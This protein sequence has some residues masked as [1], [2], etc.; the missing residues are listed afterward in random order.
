[1]ALLQTEL[2]YPQHSGESIEIRELPVPRHESAQRRLRRYCVHMA[3]EDSSSP[4][5]HRMKTIDV[6]LCAAALKD[7]VLAAD[8]LSE[9]S[10]LFDE[11]INTRTH[12]GIDVCPIVMSHGGFGRSSCLGVFQTIKR[13]MQAEGLSLQNA[14]LLVDQVVIS[15]KAIR[16]PLFVPTYQQ[17]LQL[18][19]AVRSYWTEV[20][21]QQ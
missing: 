10:T 6:T 4:N 13:K 2:G 17:Y 1:M 15:G 14:L 11:V 7:G 20:Y 16:S 21:G 19:M 5:G 12:R 9:C 3:I 18:Q 8:D